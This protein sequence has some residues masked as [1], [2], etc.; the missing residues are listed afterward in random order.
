MGGQGARTRLNERHRFDVLAPCW[1]RRSSIAPTL[2]AAS[3]VTSVAP[4]SMAGHAI[5]KSKSVWHAT[6]TRLPREERVEGG[7]GLS[8]PGVRFS[9]RRSPMVLFGDSSSTARTLN[10]QLRTAA[11]ARPAATRT[12]GCCFRRGREN[13]RCDPR[14]IR[15]RARRVRRVRAAWR[16]QPRCQ[17]H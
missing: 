3:F 1:R 5:T 4:C 13:A 12:A 7:A 11:A 14:E 15:S 6:V 10:R 9:R 17:R 8:L 16:R 2:E